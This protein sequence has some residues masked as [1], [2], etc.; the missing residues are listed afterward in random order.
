MC[1]G[2]KNIQGIQPDC[3]V[4]DLE[5]TDDIVTLRENQANLSPVLDRV[6][7]GAMAVDLEKN[8]SKT[9]FFTIVQDL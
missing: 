4:T 6:G 1:R 2:P 9:K 8:I 7:C 5:L 3:W